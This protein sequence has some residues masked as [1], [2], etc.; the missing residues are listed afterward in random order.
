[1]TF[2][3]DPKT[4]ALGFAVAPPYDIGGDAGQLPPSPRDH[5]YVMAETGE[6]VY[7]EVDFV[8]PGQGFDFAWRRTYRSALE[9]ES[10]VGYGWTHGAE[11]YLVEKNASGNVGAWFGDGR[12]EDIYVHQNGIYTSPDGYWDELHKLDD[13]GTP[14]FERTE[15]T[16][17]RWTFSQVQTGTVKNV[18]VC[19]K[20]SDPYGNSFTLNYGTGATRMRL[21]KITDT[22][23]HTVK[24]SYTAGPT[25]NSSLMSRVEV[26]A[27]D[28]AD[29]GMLTVDYTYSG[30]QL[31]E[32]Q[33]TNTRQVDG[34][35]IVRP[36]RPTATGRRQMPGTEISK[37]LPTRA[38]RRAFNSII[39][40]L[41][42]TAA[43]A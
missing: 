5:A 3:G 6:V 20:I 25:Q 27:T 28:I 43:P 23:G 14:Y 16:G 32:V 11:L 35:P 7:S 9:F 13:N 29:Y 37:R 40:L 19:T 22:V 38:R 21:E 12:A 10:W 42:L 18:Y 2:N 8:L 17:V 39:S 34:G 30:N 33:K 1:M 31:T 4:A 36:Q 24:F 41:G 26:E 15:K